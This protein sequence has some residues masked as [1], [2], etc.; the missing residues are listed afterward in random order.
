MANYVY[1]SVQ[2]ER[3]ND[4]AYAAMKAINQRVADIDAAMRANG[5]RFNH[6]NCYELWAD[7]QALADTSNW[8]TLFDEIGSKWAYVEDG[9]DNYIRLCSAWGYPEGVCLRIAREI[10]AADPQALVSISYEDEGPNFIGSALY[11]DGE[12]YD[13]E[14]I[15][16]ESYNHYGLKFWWDEEEE[17]CEEPDDFEPTWEEAHEI[18]ERDIAEMIRYYDESKE[19]GE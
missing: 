6:V 18:R 10:M 4:A 2:V 1:T 9:D 17:G 13:E 7:T 16:S 5:D 14:Y 19:E 3:G 12:M 8:T 11:A 15:S